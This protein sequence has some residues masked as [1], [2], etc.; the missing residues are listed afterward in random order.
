MNASG[1]PSFDPIRWLNHQPYLLLS[2]TALFW[3]GNWIT[4]KALAPLVPPAALTF[5]RW[6]IALALISPVVAPRLWAHR[7]V[8]REHWRP[9][10]LLGLLVNRH[11]RAA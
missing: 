4:G 6:A 3:A 7:E 1:P 11:E 8:I 10:A 5:W 2:L 9:I